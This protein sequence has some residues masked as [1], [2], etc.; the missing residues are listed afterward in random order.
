L[1]WKAALPETIA[2]AEAS[3][4]LRPADTERKQAGRLFSNSVAMAAANVLGRGVG[5]VYL[6]LM[7]RRLDA[8][9]LGIYAVLV[10]AAM[11]VELLSNL[12]LDKILIREIAS[13][14]AA[15]GQGLFLTALPL[16]LATA[17]VC[18]PAAWALLFYFLKGLSLAGPASCALFLSAIFP[19][20]A[21]RNCEAFLTAHERLLPVAVSQLSERIVILGAALLL[22]F[23]HL[24]FSTLLC[25][26]PLAALVRLLV[27][28]QST[29]RIW[30]HVP[31]TRP[32]LGQVVH[33]A[34][35]LFSV[36]ILALVYFRS[37]VFIL[38]RM[39]GLRSAGVYQISYKIFDL[40]LSLFTGFLQAVFPRMVRD[41]SRRSLKMILAGGVGLLAIPVGIIILGR[42]RILGAF[43]P[44]YVA[45]STSLVW[46]MLTVPLVFIN[47]TCAN[48][49]IA[50]G[51]IRILIA[52]AGLLIV[53]NVGL[54]L[55]LIPKW[56]INGAAFSTF[57]CE[58]LSTLVI[59]P[60]I[61][62]MLSRSPE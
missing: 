26:A 23:D 13:S 40:C 28:A 1:S 34:I 58:F 16:R 41:K 20:V 33:Q 8:R 42:R 4:L 10:T 15:T 62:R 17:A 18:A 5:Y 37:D 2:V 50:A 61:M 19:T 60:F 54:N 55:L 52:L 27:V 47:S 53:T 39:D 46:L 49:A 51:R 35:Q 3:S 48:A 38:A 30:V 6:I 45:G 12:G 22:V 7:A 9:Y 29:V 36:E 21:S 57:A 14:G 24:S 25:V 59:C 11:L 31:P 32:H 56:S 44:E 43:R